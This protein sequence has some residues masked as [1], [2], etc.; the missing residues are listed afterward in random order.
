LTS[1]KINDLACAGIANSESW[2]SAQFDRAD[3]GVNWGA[4]YGFK[5]LT[6]LQIQVEGVKAD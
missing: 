1:F 3:Y 5:T 6:Q 4:N 2:A